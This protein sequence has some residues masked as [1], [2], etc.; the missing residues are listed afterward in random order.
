VSAFIQRLLSFYNPQLGLLNEQFTRS[1]LQQEL[2]QTFYPILHIATHGQFGI[3]PEDTFLVAG[4]NQKL[5]I[6]DLERDIR[7]FSQ[8]SQRVDLLALSAC[9]TAVGDER[10]ALG[11]A[12]IAVQAGVRNALASLWSVNDE[13][14]SLLMQRFYD[15]LAQGMM[16]P[17]SSMTKAEALQKAQLSLLNSQ[18]GAADGESR[19]SIAVRPLPDKPASSQEEFSHPYYWAPFILIGS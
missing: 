3:I 10:V 18:Q 15:F 6:T 11:F 7:R 2:E 1:S 14:T 17:S 13:S 4:N 12:G 19:T 16:S 8:G 9:Q 5:T